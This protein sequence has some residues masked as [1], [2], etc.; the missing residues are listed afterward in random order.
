MIVM[1]SLAG[2][3]LCP[4]DV[5]VVEIQ[6]PVPETGIGKCPRLLERLPGSRMTLKAES[7]RILGI[8]CI[9][10][11]GIMTFQQSIFIYGM[12]RVAIATFPLSKGFMEGQPLACI[13]IFWGRQRYPFGILHLPVMTYKA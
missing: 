2:S 12:R 5:P 10:S 8:G 11:F 9:K 6:I 13:D 1:A 3:S 4:V 7:V